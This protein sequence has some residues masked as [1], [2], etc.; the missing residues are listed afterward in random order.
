MLLLIEAAHY[1]LFIVEKASDPDE[2]DNAVLTYHL[3]EPSTDSYD[4]DANKG[5]LFV[6]GMDSLPSIDQNVT[7]TVKD[8]GGL[9]KSHQVKVINIFCPPFHTGAI[10]QFSIR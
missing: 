2:G 6:K 8:L 4:I 1:V 9:S 5:H 7:V 3:S 10:P